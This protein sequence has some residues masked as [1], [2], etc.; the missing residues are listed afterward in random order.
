MKEVHKWGVFEADFK[1]S[2]SYGDPFRDV[3][4]S[5]IFRSPTGREFVV[6][7]FWNGGSTW[8]VRFMPDELGV[9][10]Y[11]TLCS[12]SGDEGLHNQT[13]FFESVPYEGENPIYIH[14]A[15]KLSDNRRYLVHADGVPYFWLADTA[16]NGVL[17]S[18]VA[19][20]SKYLKIRREQGFTAVQF[21]VTHWRGGPCDV[22]R[23]TAYEGRER[24]IRLNVEFFKRIDVKFSMV[25]EYGLVAAPVLLWA[26]RDDISPGSNLTDGDALLLARYLVA[27]YGAY[28]LVWILAGDGDYRGGKAERWKFIG[29]AVFQGRSRHPVTM[30]PAG[31]HWLLPEFLH[32]EWLDIVGYQSGHGVSEDDLKWLCFGPPSRDWLLEPA[33]PFINLEPNYEGHL[34]YRVFKPITA[35]MVRRAAYWSLLVAPPAGV[36]YGTNGVWYWSRKPE[37]PINHPHIG[38]AKPWREAV[39][40]PGAWSMGRLRRIFSKIPWWVLRPDHELL[41]EQ[42]GFKHVELFVAACRSEK[43]EIAL[44]YTPEMQSLNLNLSHMKKPFEAVWI[45]PRREEEVRIGVFSCDRLN[46]TPPGPGDWLLILKALS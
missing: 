44:I 22:E 24:I 2:S 36:S 40:L 7:G 5:C 37:V 10:S 46:L 12:N 6:D 8:C 41:V 9:W 16:W 42:P 1:S 3:S 45:N 30:H 33:R 18:T 4:L 38:V 13:G 14:G 34:A 28:I 21:V 35:H 17:R 32:E 26:I 19:E 25:N 39:N 15:L 11:R 31:R 23:E 27:R 29:R 43:G 20:W